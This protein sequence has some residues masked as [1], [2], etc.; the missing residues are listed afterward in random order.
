MR[1]LAFFFIGLAGVGVA[2]IQPDDQSPQAQRAA[3]RETMARHG[4]A[5]SGR[6]DIGKALTIAKFSSPTCEDV[7]VLPVSILFQET[8]L[9]RK[10]E[11]ADDDR[12]FFY[13]NKAWK[14]DAS[15]NVAL[16]H[17]SQRFLQMI[18]LRPDPAIDTM[19]YIVSPKKCGVP[20]VDWSKFWGQRADI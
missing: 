8:A 12:A 6:L 7:R 16:S 17:L 20:Q 9:L 15:N 19:L 4:Y 11:S 14:D 1:Y 18:R 3:I 13:I 10:S 2:L 5:A